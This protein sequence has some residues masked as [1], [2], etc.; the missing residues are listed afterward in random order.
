M[1]YIIEKSRSVGARVKSLFKLFLNV[2]RHSG[3]FQLSPLI[4][5]VYG[6]LP[7]YLNILVV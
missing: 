1:S 7:L 3:S 5:S 6:D 2:I 4:C